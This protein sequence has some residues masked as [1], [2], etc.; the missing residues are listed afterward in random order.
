MTQGNKVIFRDF[1]ATETLKTS[2]NTKGAEIIPPQNLT[3]TNNWN[4]FC[5]FETDQVCADIPLNQCPT[6][7]HYS[8]WLFFT[9]IFLL[10]VWILLAN[11]FVIAYIIKRKRS[12]RT[13]LDLLKGSLAVTDLL[14]GFLLFTTALPNIAWT[15]RLTSRQLYV[16][17]R[18]LADTPVAIVS[19]TL[20]LLFI[21]STL[22]HLVL[23]SYN[24]FAAIKWPLAPQ[25]VKKT[26]INLLL[27]WLLALAAASYPAWFPGF[28][29][30]YY[31][32][33]TF[34]FLPNIL[35]HS[36]VELG[37]AVGFFLLIVLPYLAMM[38]I[39]S[40]T[41]IL[42]LRG[43]R[44]AR[45]QLS[46]SSRV[47]EQIIRR[48]KTVLTTL[49]TMKIGFTITHV[50]TIIVLGLSFIGISHPIALIFMSYCALC[51]SAINVLIYRAKDQDFKDF[52]TNVL[53]R[54]FRWRSTMRSP[55]PS[56]NR[57]TSAV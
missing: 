17:T 57:V 30:F 14:T 42:I 37:Q 33:F 1:T 54:N 26:K 22:Y 16:E 2:K 11:S 48:E 56:N 5:S 40:A 25:T 35:I 39:L 50:P 7:R 55:N 51:N 43:N 52:V 29:H 12:L 27:L 24:R 13:S 34:L 23:M 45:E 41:A 21:Y 20:Y 36:S 53:G 19:A 4:T 10:A 18:K 46:E 38:V 15:T 3:W 44:K 49:A 31:T 47:Q 9:L 8:F 28:F 32:Y 6:C